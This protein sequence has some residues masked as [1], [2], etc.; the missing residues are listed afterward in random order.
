V[1]P[2]DYEGSP[3]VLLEAL[4]LGVPAVGSRVGGTPDILG[5]ER[6]MFPPGDP[7]AAAE[8]ANRLLDGHGRV[9]R[10]VA[11]AWHA[12]AAAFRFDW[13]KRITELAEAMIAAP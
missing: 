1:L 8:C 11:E 6:L 7:A 9:R 13:E 10:D 4:G 2:S 12:R 3:L 5:E